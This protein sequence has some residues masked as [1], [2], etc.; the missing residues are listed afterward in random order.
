MGVPVTSLRFLFNGR[1]INDDETPK[2][3]EMEQV[4]G[5]YGIDWLVLELFFGGLFVAGG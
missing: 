5:C 3:L 1:R 4:A 2:A